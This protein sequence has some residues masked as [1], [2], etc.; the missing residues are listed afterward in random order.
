M[1][2][3]QPTASRWG[4]Q[5][6]YLRGVTYGPIHPREDGSEFRTP[7]VVARDFSMMAAGVNAVRVYTVPPGWL[8]DQAR[9]P[10]RWDWPGVHWRI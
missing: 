2:S 8:L 3:P 1:A 5:K 9:E 10:Q 7:N 4:D 6:L